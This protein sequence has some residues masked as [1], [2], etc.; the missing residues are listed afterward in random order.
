MKKENCSGYIFLKQVNVIFGYH[1]KKNDLPDVTDDI[2]R[3]KLSYL[4]SKKTPTPLL[5]EKVDVVGH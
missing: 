5:S 2:K 4:L 1:H 3:L